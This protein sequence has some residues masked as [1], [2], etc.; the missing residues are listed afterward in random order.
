MQQKD[1]LPTPGRPAASLPPQLYKVASKTPN[2]FRPLKN[3]TSIPP[4]VYNALPG[5][6]STKPRSLL[7]PA[8][9]PGRRSYP[10][11]SSREASVLPAFSGQTNLHVGRSSKI[12][13]LD[14]L[15]QSLDGNPCA[16][17]WSCCQGPQFDQ[18]PPTV[19]GG[20]GSR[21]MIV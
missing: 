9:L 21:V 19:S 4:N 18:V 15:I 7:A 1:P 10:G 11:G 16:G 13:L 17:L 20:I 12:A 8:G 3:E 14:C 5:P 2:D 6:T